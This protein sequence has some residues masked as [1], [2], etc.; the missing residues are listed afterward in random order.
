MA[1][2]NVEFSDNF[3]I[4]SGCHLFC[5]FHAHI[6]THTQRP[7]WRH[8]YQNTD[9]LIFVVDSNDRDRLPEC[10]DELWRF[11]QEDELKDC[12]LLVL[13]NKQDL[14]N[15]M[16]TQEITDK[17]ELNSITDRKWCKYINYCI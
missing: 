17:L 15:A 9:A 3:S 1:S 4:I 10:K 12:V 8:Y 6:H 11:T 16:T 2:D 13:A 14:P 5:C 7:L